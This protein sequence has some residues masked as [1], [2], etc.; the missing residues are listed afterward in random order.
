M[1]VSTW[2]PICLSAHARTTVGRDGRPHLQESR[3]IANTYEM[4]ALRLGLETRWGAEAWHL[5]HTHGIAYHIV[6]FSFVL[7]V[8]GARQAGSGWRSCGLPRV[9]L[10]WSSLSHVAL[11]C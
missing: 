5:D 6:M 7:V 8:F 3:T 9:D 11:S 1:R 10:V 4:G 2:V